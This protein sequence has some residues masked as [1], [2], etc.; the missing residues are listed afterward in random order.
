MVNR[1]RRRPVKEESPV[2]GTQYHVNKGQAMCSSG[3]TV[4]SMSNFGFP[5]NLTGLAP[6]PPKTKQAN[7]QKILE[8]SKNCDLPVS[9]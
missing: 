2:T 8:A 7:K 1:R 3:I 6:C 5:V 4:G 9:V